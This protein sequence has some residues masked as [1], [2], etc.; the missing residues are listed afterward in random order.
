[1]VTIKTPDE[2]GSLYGG[3]RASFLYSQRAGNYLTWDPLGLRTYEVQNNIQWPDSRD[4]T[5]RLEKR[6]TLGPNTMGLFME[7]YNL[8]DWKS[9][10]ALG[11]FDTEDRNLYFKSLHLEMYKEEPWRSAPGFTPP[12][13]GEEPDKVG[14]IW[15]EEKPYINMPNY[16][17]LTFLNP[18]N[19]TFGIEFNF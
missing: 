1:M 12:E 11:F 16:T 5:L 2:W 6:I 7:V 3:Y 15:S 18:R 4:L 17:H 13:E 9:L 14:D 19:I 10:N 8:F